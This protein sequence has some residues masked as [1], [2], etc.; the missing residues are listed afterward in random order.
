MCSERVHS[1]SD[2]L[3]GNAIRHNRSMRGNN[4]SVVGRNQKH[5]GGRIV[6][7]VWEPVWVVFVLPPVVIQLLIVVGRVQNMGGHQNRLQR[8]SHVQLGTGVEFPSMDTALA[9]RP[10]LERPDDTLA[11]WGQ[12]ESGVE[13]TVCGKEGKLLGIGTA[14]VIVEKG[15]RSNAGRIR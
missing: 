8:G 11:S 10:C 5:N 4:T 12:T 14:G 6:A 2:I 1:H 15:I 13:V 9:R 3:P 7:I